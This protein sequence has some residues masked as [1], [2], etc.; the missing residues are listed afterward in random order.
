[1]ASTKVKAVVI[2]GVNVKEKDKI[3]YLYSLEMGK[4]SV[5]MRGVRGEKAKLKFAKEPFC[6]GEYY[7]EEAHNTYIVTAVD[8]ID[9]FYDLS[10]DIEKYYEASAILDIVDKTTGESN[11]QVFIELI[12]ALKTL[13][14]EDV[15]K[16]Y[17]ID[18][19]LLSLF[20]AMGY[21]FLSDRCSSC[22]SLLGLK[23]FNL[24]IGDIV[25]PACKTS[26]CIPIS[27]A[28]YSALRII[29]STPYEK[30]SSV[31]LGGMGEVQAYNLLGQNYEWRTGY[32]L[33]KMIQKRMKLRITYKR[34]DGNKK[35]VSFNLMCYFALLFL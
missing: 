35:E 32:S 9:N 2:K 5:S 15:K 34:N 29:D 18:K 7:L 10:K 31:K 1:M 20:G 16:Y 27:D 17:V 4:I 13:C 14:Y 25:C 21:Q 24:D 30:L 28:C 11:P 22:N 33:L 19:F 26:A 12:K 3:I 8:V 6:F 23:Y